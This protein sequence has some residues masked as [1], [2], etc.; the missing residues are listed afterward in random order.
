MWSADPDPIPGDTPGR[1]NVIRD[2]QG[3]I[4]PNIEAVA[5][6]VRYTPSITGMQFQYDEFLGQI[7]TAGADPNP[8]PIKDVDITQVKL[9]LETRGDYKD[10]PLDLLRHVVRMVADSVKCDSA[11]DWIDRLPAWDRVPRVA[12]FYVDYLGCQNTAYA[13]A[14][15]LYQWTGMAARVLEPG[16]QL[17]IT[18]IWVGDQGTR[19]TSSVRALVPH[20]DFFGS[21]DLSMKDADFSRK[22][23]GV[24]VGEIGELKGLNGRDREA[25]KDLL[26]RTTEVWSEKYVEHATR[27][28]RRIFMIATTNSDSFLDDPTGNRR[29]APIRTGL[30]DPDAIRRDLEQLWAEG[31][32]LYRQG[33]IQWQAVSQLAAKEHGQFE[34]VDGWEERVRKYLEGADADS[35]VSREWTT[36]ADVLEDGLYLQPKDISRASEMRVSAILKKLGWVKGRE[37]ID[38]I[39][40]RVYVREAAK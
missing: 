9:N 29:F 35:S 13:T 39:Q 3:R 17:D 20:D 36:V 25:V 7:V 37:M 5:G 15:G 4:T 1:Y 18:P 27:Y 33:G 2:K 19:K 31:V 23:R 21:I 14:L 28:K 34:Q 22:V 24:L 8:R 32:V 30:C 16:C 11:K 10:V 40:R 26:T 12:R 6:A 38:G